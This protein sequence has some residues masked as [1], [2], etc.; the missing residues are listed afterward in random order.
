M[1]FEKLLSGGDLRSIGKCEKVIAQ[2]RTQKDFDN[3][4]AYLFHA[5]RLVVMRAADALEK[6]TRVHPE[7]LAKHKKEMFALFASAGNKELKWHIPVM[8]AR[9]E[10]SGT[11]FKKVWKGI[12]EWLYDKN[13]SKLVRV[14][15]LQGLYE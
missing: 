7:Y 13:N 11:E 2:V 4:F 14:G 9:L 15:A 10:F 8:M 1:N 3:L 6:I 5:D 12:V